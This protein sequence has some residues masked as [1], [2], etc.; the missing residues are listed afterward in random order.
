MSELNNNMTNEGQSNTPPPINPT[1]EYQNNTQEQQNSFNNQ[2][3]QPELP[4]NNLALAIIATVSGFLTCCGLGGCASIVLGIIAIVFASNVNSK[5]A[6]GD[7]L[8]ANT[9]ARRAK[10]LSLI[11]L[12]LAALS[13]I[14][15]IVS[16]LTISADEMSQIQDAIEQ[17]K[18]SLEGLD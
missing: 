15:V 5:Y 3:I 2:G 13:I 11:A 7:Y 18:E 9:M 1:P 4:N 12:G 6:K 8:G 14:Y 16:Y 10:T 17:L